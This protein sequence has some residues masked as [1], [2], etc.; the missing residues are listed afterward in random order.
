MPCL[1]G[2]LSQDVQV[3][4]EPAFAN[5]FRLLPS[6]CVQCHPLVTLLTPEGQGAC[7]LI[8]LLAPC[9]VPGATWH[10]GGKETAI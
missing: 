1:G 9:T 8:L 5:A 6:L 7:F 4:H 2:D 3:N 10:L